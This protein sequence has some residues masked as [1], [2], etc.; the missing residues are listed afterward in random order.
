MG[1]E[2][3]RT[4]EGVEMGGRESG[5]V[6]VQVQEAMWLTII[7]LVHSTARI[8]QTVPS[9]VELEGGARVM[10]SSSQS[11]VSS[12]PWVPEPFLVLLP[13][14]LAAVTFKVAQTGH[15][16][17]SAH[18]RSQSP[19]CALSAASRY[20]RAHPSPPH[21]RSCKRKLRARQVAP[22]TAKVGPQKHRK[23]LRP[24]RLLIDYAPVR[25][26]SAPDNS[27]KVD[28]TELCSVVTVV[29]RWSPPGRH[30][31]SYSRLAEA[32]LPTAA[33]GSLADILPAG[34]RYRLENNRL[35][36][37]LSKS[38][39]MHLHDICIHT[40]DSRFRSGR[41]RE[42]PVDVKSFA[43]SYTHRRL[44]HITSDYTDDALA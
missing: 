14:L 21:V 44:V 1:V 32:R 28:S 13:T 39:S 26:G 40:L 19:A 22:R 30:P 34:A 24:S 43:A 25:H 11:P 12:E 9:S 3:E 20:R 35:L 18:F 16:T 31:P 33:A 29:A 38:Q 42:G 23:T 41:S 36:S 10:K 2:Q 4:S 6:V 15:Q 7:K 17:D 37:P 27:T 5:K 8:K